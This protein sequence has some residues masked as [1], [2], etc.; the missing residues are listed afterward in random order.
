[1]DQTSALYGTFKFMMFVVA[2]QSIDLVFFLLNLVWPERD[3]DNVVPAGF[4][5]S[6]PPPF[7][8]HPVLFVAVVVARLL[9]PRAAPEC[10]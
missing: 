10:E 5:V 2:L 9:G 3:D 6:I 4:S 7:W 1:L 8:Q